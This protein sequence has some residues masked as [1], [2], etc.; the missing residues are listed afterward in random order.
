METLLV[1]WHQVN[2]CKFHSRRSILAPPFILFLCQYRNIVHVTELSIRMT[3]Y[4]NAC[5]SVKNRCCWLLF[6]RKTCTNSLFHSCDLSTSTCLLLT[7]ARSQ[8]SIVT[9]ESS[10]YPAGLSCQ[11]FLLFILENKDKPVKYFLDSFWHLWGGLI[12]RPCPVFVPW[13]VL[14]FV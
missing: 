6:E 8:C 12:A 1:W 13:Q 11:L 4:Q 7:K 9:S 5:D 10:G 14:V 2:N 3:M